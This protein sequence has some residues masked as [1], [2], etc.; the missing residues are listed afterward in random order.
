MDRDSNEK[1]K[2]LKG[3]GLRI[4]LRSA[5]FSINIVSRSSFMRDSKNWHEKLREKLS[6]S[7]NPH[8]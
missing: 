5:I 6:C 2:T 3:G 1:Y 4:R 7:L 8:F